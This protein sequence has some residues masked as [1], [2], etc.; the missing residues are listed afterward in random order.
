MKKMNREGR[1]DRKEVM[2]VKEE[3]EK[4]EWGWEGKEREGRSGNKQSEGW[5]EKRRERGRELEKKERRRKKGGKKEDNSERGRESEKW[6]KSEGWKTKKKTRIEMYMNRN[7][8]LFLCPSKKKRENNFSVALKP[9]E[10][11]T[12]SKT[13]EKTKKLIYSG[14]NCRYCVLSFCLWSLELLC[15]R[16][17]ANATIQPWLRIKMSI[18]YLLTITLSWL[19]LYFSPMYSLYNIFPLSAYMI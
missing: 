19:H 12:S 11:Y 18:A 7:L 2:D 1:D 15:G 3:S 6:D 16:S 14:V 17:R 10:I 5:G 4:D 8:N 9:Q 13:T